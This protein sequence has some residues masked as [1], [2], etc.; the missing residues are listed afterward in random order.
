MIER[1]FLIHR[2]PT[3]TEIFKTKEYLQQIETITENLRNEMTNGNS[4][5]IKL[6]I[7]KREIEKLVGENEN[8]RLLFCTEKI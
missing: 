1:G 7:L 3:S 2:L 4:D 8:L 6:E 5:K